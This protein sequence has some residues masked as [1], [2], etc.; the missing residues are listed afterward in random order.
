M[1]SPVAL[2]VVS[3]LTLVYVVLRVFTAAPQAFPASDAARIQYA[4]QHCWGCGDTGP[5]CAIATTF[6]TWGYYSEAH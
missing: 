4:I 3:V 1:K 2:F 5:S 6:W